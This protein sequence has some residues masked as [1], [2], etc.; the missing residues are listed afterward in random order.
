VLVTIAVI[1]VLIS[2]LAPSL[3]SVRDTAQQVVCR[4]NVRQLGIGIDLYAEDYKGVV[5]ASKAADLP[6]GSIE[7]MTLRFGAA[8]A[9]LSNHWDGLGQLYIL[10]YLPAPKL[11]YCPSHKGNNPFARYVDQ[12][13][14][15]D[16]V[17]VG[18]Y[19]YR[20]HGPVLM[21]VTT[22]T[23]TMPVTTV[24]ASIRPSA[25]IVSDGLR[26]QA[27]FNHVIGANVLRSDLSV[28]WFNDSS[29]RIFD[30]LPKDGQPPSP[31]TV[32]SAWSELDSGAH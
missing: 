1:G 12:W 9:N 30:H 14:G 7:T 28:G 17:I 18:N 24:L 22:N 32:D 13:G 15:R 21:T 3:A 16:G 26:T 10:D 27:D 4:S 31:A 6:S 2:I 23:N 25:A 19:Q 5:P 29:G 20:G 11:Y 8:P